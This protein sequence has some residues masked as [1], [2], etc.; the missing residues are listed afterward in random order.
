MPAAADHNLRPLPLPAAYELRPVVAPAAATTTAASAPAA[1]ASA[2]LA[3]AVDEDTELA[4]IERELQRLELEK[5]NVRRMQ[6]I[7]LLTPDVVAKTNAMTLELLSLSASQAEDS[8][9]DADDK[10]ARGLNESPR[11]LRH[12]GVQAHIDTGDEPLAQSLSRYRSMRSAEDI[13]TKLRKLRVILNK[14]SAEDLPKLV[15]S[16][17]DLNI[18]NEDLMS[19]VAQTVFDKAVSEPQHSATYAKFCDGIKDIN[20]LSNRYRQ[21]SCTMAEGIAAA[22]SPVDESKSFRRCILNLCQDT[23]IGHTYDSYTDADLNTMEA[24][25]RST[26]LAARRR[27]YGAIRFF[28]ELY[29]QGMLSILVIVRC[30]DSLLHRASSCENAVEALCCLVSTTGKQLD[31]EDREK[32][33]EF[34]PQLKAITI[35]KTYS[36]RVLSLMGDIV[37]LRDLKWDAGEEQGEGGLGTA[38]GDLN[39]DVNA[40]SA[41]MSDLV[42]SLKA[43]ADNGKLEVTNALVGLACAR[44][45]EHLLIAARD[46][47]I[48]MVH[49]L[50]AC[51]ARLNCKNC[52]RQT[53]LIQAI[54]FGHEEVAKLLV[55]SN[56]VIEHMDGAGMSPLM[57]AAMYG[58]T[59]A[60][61]ALVGARA[62]LDVTLGNHRSALMYAAISGHSL[63]VEVL[64]GARA[65]LE[66]R[67][68]AGWTALMHA[69]DKGHYDV[70]KVLIDYRADMNA[71]CPRTQKTPLTIAQEKG[72]TAIVQLLQNPRT[73]G[74]SRED[75]T[76][77]AEET[78]DCSI[79]YVPCLPDER[80]QILAC[81]HKYHH[82]CIEK[83]L[84]R[85]DSCPMCR[86][87]VDD[88]AGEDVEDV[89]GD[90]DDEDYEDFQLYELY[91]GDSAFLP[92]DEDD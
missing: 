30:I 91:G 22:N 50:I 26:V 85:A 90:E 78:V 31:V 47:D 27:F 88:D 39:I 73:G 16:V 8:E 74:V 40:N 19:E 80:L 81:R 45:Q 64:L 9:E 79:C 76:S 54:I 15:Q 68:H 13:E 14:L 32:L 34:M 86:R 71:R 67:D 6:R 57:W 58:R 83:W 2:T 87:I 44:E 3:D 5:Q 43:A 69:A 63:A 29:L 7:V 24:E 70:T 1:A 84:R 18:D 11:D 38:F 23:F 92:A 42:R 35:E 46:G 56:A 60:L 21:G 20:Y 59:E 62:S 82:N 41:L 17:E 66:A 28:G 72:H 51:G 10:P 77:R 55:N 12:G 52:I 36:P 37:K 4:R 49:V 65:P 61:I 33:D 53:P 89:E 75:A 48:D 25:Q